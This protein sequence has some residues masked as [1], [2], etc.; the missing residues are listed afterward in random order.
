M[1]KE[2]KLKKIGEKINCT[3]QRKTEGP[4]NT[5]RFDGNIKK[6]TDVSCLLLFDGER[7]TLYK[8]TNNIALQ[9][10]EAGEP[11]VFNKLNNSE[12]LSS[13]V[14]T[15]QTKRKK[16]SAET[17]SN[18]P[19]KKLKEKIPSTS[20]ASINSKIDKINQIESNFGI[21]Q[22]NQKTTQKTHTESNPN[23]VKKNIFLLYFYFY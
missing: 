3:F 15:T 11:I 8:I 13:I 7:F 5:A 12:K 23:R 19:N 1:N 21:Y 4:T 10:K 14:S 2:G 20:S 16:D 6:S 22:K 18:A 9:Y 17:N